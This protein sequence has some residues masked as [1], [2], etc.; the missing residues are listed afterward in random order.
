MLVA[1]GWQGLFEVIRSGRMGANATEG[2]Y[3]SGNSIGECCGAAGG[4]IE[5]RD[6]TIDL[7]HDLEQVSAQ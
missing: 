4:I 5:Q 1:F 2:S 3:G 7:F 6:T